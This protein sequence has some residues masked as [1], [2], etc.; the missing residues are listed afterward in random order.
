MENLALNLE[1]GYTRYLMV[2]DKHSRIKQLVNTLLV[3]KLNI[4]VV[5][6]EL[7]QREDLIGVEEVLAKNNM[8]RNMEK[9]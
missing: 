7:Q 1:L 3:I 8:T 2:V 5:E 9:Q 4:L 6:L